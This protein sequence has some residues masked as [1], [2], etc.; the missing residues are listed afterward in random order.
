MPAQRCKPKR[1]RMPHEVI[2]MEAHNDHAF[3]EELCYQQV[4]RLT[5]DATRSFELQ[6]SDA[7]I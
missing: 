2:D 6:F 4:R 1:E 7:W 3:I 5:R